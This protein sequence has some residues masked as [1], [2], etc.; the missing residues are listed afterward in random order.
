MN[1]AF[2][3]EYRYGLWGVIVGCAAVFGGG[4]ML[5]GANKKQADQLPEPSG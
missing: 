3:L 4:A 1:T 2:T 5:L